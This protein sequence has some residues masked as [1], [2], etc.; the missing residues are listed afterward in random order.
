MVASYN[1]SAADDNGGTLRFYSTVS[2]GVDM[3]LVPGWEYTGF[4]KIV[5]AVYKEVRR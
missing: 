4:A 3:T 5:D 2:P 1:S